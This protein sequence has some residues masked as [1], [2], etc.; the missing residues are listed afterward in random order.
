MSWRTLPRNDRP[1][2][3]LTL[4]RDNAGLSLRVLI[5]G[6]QC[7]IWRAIST[8]SAIDRHRERRQSGVTPMTEA[9]WM[10]D[11]LIIFGKGRSDGIHLVK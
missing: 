8:D 5:G 4:L 1:I 3:L 11:R 7:P 9:V 6:F 2:L 10:G